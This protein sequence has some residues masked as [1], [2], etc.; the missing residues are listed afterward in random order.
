MYDLNL[1]LGFGRTGE[2]ANEPHTTDGYELKRGLPPGEI[3]RK[4]VCE[5]SAYIKSL[6][7]KQ[8]VRSIPCYC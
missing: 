1:S 7:V 5:M 3:V 8:M 4:W 6:G 2:L